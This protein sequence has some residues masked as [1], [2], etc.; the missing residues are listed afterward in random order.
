MKKAVLF[1]ATLMVFGLALGGLASAGNFDG[2][3]DSARVGAGLGEADAVSGDASDIDSV[4]TTV[5]EV[6]SVIVG[7]L[8]V[9]MIIISGFKYVTSGGD[10]QKVASAK[11]TLIYAIIG[12]VI[13]VLA[14]VIV[15]FVLS[16]ATATP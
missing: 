12:I 9:I 2:A 7:V 6:L 1:V 16:S 3:I 15:R 13:V 8:A 5:V 11:S 14:Q 4:I 10:A